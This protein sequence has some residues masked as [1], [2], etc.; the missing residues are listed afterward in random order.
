MWSPVTSEEL[1]KYMGLVYF[2][3]VLSRWLTNNNRDQ[4]ITFIVM[5]SIPA[6]HSSSTSG[7]LPLEHVGPTERAEWGPQ[8]PR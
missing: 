2:M 6:W 3:G 4:V 1:C 5:T 7:I 8:Q